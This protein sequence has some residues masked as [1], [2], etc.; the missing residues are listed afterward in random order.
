MLPGFI[1][2]H[3]HFSMLMQVE[4]GIDL[5]AGDA[6]PG[7]IPALI[8]LL[9]QGVA[10]MAVGRHADAAAAA[11]QQGHPPPGRQPEQEQRQ[12]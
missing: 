8:A 1:D 2:A 12:E 3:S 6:P 4:T 9:R 5:D 11:D 7:D 10:G